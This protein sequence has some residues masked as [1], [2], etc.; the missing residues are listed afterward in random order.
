MSET[1]RR[2]VL[3]GAAGVSAAAVLAACGDKAP[4]TTPPASGDGAG[5]GNTGALA[6]TSDI[7]VGGGKV[8][9]KQKVVVTQPTAGQFK[10][11]TAICT[12]QGCTVSSV[13]NGRIK[14]PCHGSEYS[15]TDGSVK[16]GPAPQALASKSITVSGSDVV[17]G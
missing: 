5:G 9:D 17:L 8:F 6:Q 2:V 7:P 16:A 1:T 12:H 3:A 15:I 13:A 11:F 10:A 4:E 14:C